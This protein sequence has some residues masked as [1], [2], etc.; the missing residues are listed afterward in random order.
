MTGQSVFAHGVSLKSVVGFF[1]AGK[2]SEARSLCGAEPKYIPYKHLGPLVGA[3][4]PAM[5][6]A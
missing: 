6:A 4:L 5:A 3:G 2:R 1:L